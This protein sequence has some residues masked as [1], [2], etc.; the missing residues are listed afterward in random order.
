MSMTENCLNRAECLILKHLVRKWTVIRDETRKNR[1]LDDLSNIVFKY[2]MKC[3]Y[4]DKDLCHKALEVDFGRNILHSPNP[5][6][7][8]LPK[9]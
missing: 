9:A 4:F 8:E 7:Y 6:T 5:I 1:W 3:Q 2:A